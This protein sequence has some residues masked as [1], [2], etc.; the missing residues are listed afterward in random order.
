MEVFFSFLIGYFIKRVIRILIF[1]LGRILAL[2]MYLQ[3]HDIID[4]NIS[5]DK[6][7]S[8]AKAIINTV[9]A[10]AT[11]IFSNDNNPSFIE[12]NPDIPVS[13]SITTRFVLGIT[14]RG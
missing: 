8:S 9:A 3:F 4:V 13:G 11:T 1:V 5:L 14:R 6:L 7:Q 2:L 10:S 12:S